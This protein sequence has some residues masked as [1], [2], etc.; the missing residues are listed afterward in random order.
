MEEPMSILKKIFGEKKGS[1][2]SVGP[3]KVAPI[4]FTER[5]ERAKP[6]VVDRRK[7][8]IQATT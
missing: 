5:R 4:V 6:V 3:V 2:D 1:L 7:A 8:S